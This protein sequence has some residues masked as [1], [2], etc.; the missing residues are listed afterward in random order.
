MVEAVVLAAAGELLDVG[1]IGEA[2]IAV[3]EG[4]TL[5]VGNAT[6]IGSGFLL[7][8]SLGLSY[9]MY[10]PSAP[11]AEDGSQPIR[12]AVQPRQRGYWVNRLSG[13]VMLATP[14][15]AAPT[16]AYMVG[17]FHQGPIDSLIGFYM[18]DDAVTMT[19]DISHGGTAQVVASG[20][21]YAFVRFCVKLGRPAE[22]V[23]TVLTGD[24]NINGTW[25]TSYVGEGVAY[26]SMIAAAPADPTQFA[27][28]YP[29]GLPRA[30]VLAICSPI[31]D[32]RDG[33]QL[34]DTSS[35][36]VAKRNPVLQLIDY[37][38]ATDGGMG[39][40]PDEFLPPARLAQWMV[41]ASLCDV[42][43]GGGDIRYGSA[44]WYTF[45]T[46]PEDVINKILATCDGWLAPAGDGTLSLTVGVYRASTLPPITESMVLDMDVTL[47]NPDETLINEID[48]TWTNPATN[49]S[50]DQATPVQDSA[51]IAL[52]GEIKRQPLDLTWVQWP[53]QVGRLARRALL[54]ANPKRA[55]TFVG[56]EILLRYAGERWINLQ[57]PFPGLEACVIEV[58][59]FQVDH[60]AGRVTIKFIT[61]DPAP[62]AGL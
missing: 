55:G 18:D 41:E 46:K 44:G 45:D 58:Q 12:A 42:D 1:L 33:A 5:G 17:A 49:Y 3:V 15:G 7:A 52:V 34:R 38:R 16:T 35:T 56:R 11:K 50:S 27:K 19:A 30:S 48:A 40:D 32:P 21:R 4:T 54:R 43:L 60:L 25:T 24:A 53:V 28:M 29:R 51:S 57:Y 47:G 26:W 20:G 8:A 2:G 22:G 9:A 14:G 62:L 37:L 61:V 23:E 31:W 36:W 13:A 59:D 39:F 6:L 10:R